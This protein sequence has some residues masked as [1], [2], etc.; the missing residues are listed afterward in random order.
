MP[1]KKS[2]SFTGSCFNKSET[3][4][5]T[6]S[7]RSAKLQGGSPTDWSVVYAVTCKKCQLMYAGPIR[8]A[9]NCR[10]NIHRSDILCYPNPF[11]LQKHFR[12]GDWSF[13]TDLS[14]SIF[15]KVKGFEYLQKYKKDQWITQ[16][17]TIYPSGLNIHISHFGLLYSS[18]FK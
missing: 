18:L 7:K 5:N 16:L 6:S 17:D 10:F 11:E 12:Y 15:E 1:E 3:I 13:E 2:T 14:L 8:D 9:L 4:T